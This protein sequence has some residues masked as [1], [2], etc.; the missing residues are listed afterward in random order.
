MS[1]RFRVV[2]AAAARADLR[3]IARYI[4]RRDSAAAARRQLVRLRARMRTLATSP[5]R[6]HVPPELAERGIVT[7]RELVE[8]PWRMIYRIEAR[9]VH[10]LVVID[11]RRDLS[12]LL[13][14]RLTRPQ[15]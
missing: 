3:E 8:G 6:G 10:L 11:G 12:E 7:W 4:A 14:Q 2:V 5:T 15:W 1:R 9:E 13:L